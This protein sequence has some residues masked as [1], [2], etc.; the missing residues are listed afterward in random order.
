MT[1]NRQAHLALVEQL[2]AKLAVAALGVLLAARA[3]ES[4]QG[5][6]SGVISNQATRDLLRLNPDNQATVKALVEKLLGE[7][8]AAGK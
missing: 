3:Q 8:K 7:Q 1:S 4:R 6:V 5:T 2:R